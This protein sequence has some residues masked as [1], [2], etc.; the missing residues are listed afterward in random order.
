MLEKDADIAI[1]H[2]FHQLCYQKKIRLQGKIE[3]LVA[4]KEIYV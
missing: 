2:I 4:D 3:R 1:L